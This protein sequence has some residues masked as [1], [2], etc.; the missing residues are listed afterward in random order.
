VATWAAWAGGSLIVLGLIALAVVAWIRRL[1]T[2][3]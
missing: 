3:E 1:K 2:T